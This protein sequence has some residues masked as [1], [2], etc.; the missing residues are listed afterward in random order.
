MKVSEHVRATFTPDGAVL[1]NIKGGHMITLNPIGSII[2]Q[3]LTDGRSPA[4]I[5]GFL[6]SDFGI[7]L[8]Q[9]LADVNEFL[10]QLEAQHLIGPSEPEGFRINLGPKLTGLFCTL[11]GKRNSH[12]VQE[13]GSR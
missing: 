8:E 11:F 5:A 13:R 7:P 9:A 6:A 3:Q 4:Q 2:W 1:M 12:Q 10:E